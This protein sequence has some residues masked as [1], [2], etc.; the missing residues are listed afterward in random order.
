ME[1]L[2]S[3]IDLYKTYLNHLLVLIVTIGAGVT[4]MF[5]K[6]DFTLAFWV[7]SVLLVL[8]MVNYAILAY[9]LNKELKDIKE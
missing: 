9:R 4:N 1:K 5:T 8:S 6:G 2:K 3:K 7:G